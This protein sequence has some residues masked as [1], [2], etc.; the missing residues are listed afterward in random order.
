MDRA[1]DIEDQIKAKAYEKTIMDEKYDHGWEGLDCL[2]VNVEYKEVQP[3][4][5]NDTS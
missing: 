5:E 3:E 4:T 2:E 1:T